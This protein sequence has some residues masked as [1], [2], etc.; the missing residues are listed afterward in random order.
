MC[1][2]PLL[3]PRWQTQALDVNSRG[4]RATGLECG[5]PES[6]SGIRVST[7]H[8]PFTLKTQHRMSRLTL[9]RGSIAPL[10]LIYMVLASFSL[11]ACGCGGV[12]GWS[13]LLGLGISARQWKTFLCMQRLFIWCGIFSDACH[14]LDIWIIFWIQSDSNTHW[15]LH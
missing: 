4:S 10:A 7:R 15:A 12:E 9:V 14:L 6:S 2:K 11:D 8:V 13:R 1:A 5:D 3:T